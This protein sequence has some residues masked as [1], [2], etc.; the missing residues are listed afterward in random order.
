MLYLLHLLILIKI[1]WV[2]QGEY[3]LLSSIKIRLL[4]IWYINVSGSPLDRRWL[5]LKSVSFNLTM[6]STLTTRVTKERKI[7]SIIKESGIGNIVKLKT[8]QVISILFVCFLSKNVE[9]FFGNMFSGKI[10]K[11]YQKSFYIIY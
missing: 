5:F 4:M 3:I 7:S 1:I 10:L 11:P 2:F 8:E 9:T 6:Y